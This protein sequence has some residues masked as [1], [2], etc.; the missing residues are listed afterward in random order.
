M[1]R[2]ALLLAAAT[3]ASLLS[4]GE[5]E[6]E[7]PKKPEAT[8]VVESKPTPVDIH[9]P[10]PTEGLDGIQLR[11]ANLVNTEDSAKY[12]S[13]V[14][15]RKRFVGD[16]NGVISGRNSNSI[17][18]AAALVY[19]DGLLLS[20]FLGNNY[21]FGPRWGTVAP[22]EIER[23]DLIY[24]PYSALYPGNSMGVTAWITTRE[25]QKLEA[26]LRLQ[27]FTQAYSDEYGF[28]RTFNG[29]QT[30][31]W[32]GDR[33]GR[34][35]YSVGVNHLDNLGQP[36][37]YATLLASATTTGTGPT[38]TGAGHDLDPTN[39]RRLVL[40]PTN[41]EHTVQDQAKLRFGAFITP[42]FHVAFTVAR[43]QNHFTRSSESWL[44]D[45]TG[46]PLW[47]GRTVIDGLT[48]NLSPSSPIFPF[49]DGTEATTLMGLTAK[50]KLGQSWL[51]EAILSGYQVDKDQLGSN[52][53]AA[54]AGA[55]GGAGQVAFQDGT[56]WRTGDLKAT[57]EAIGGQ[58]HLALGLH[59][60]HYRLNNRVFNATDWRQGTLTTLGSR[61]AGQ[62][63]TQAAYV[64]DAWLFSPTWTLT[65]G[66]RLER[67]KAY[68]GLIQSGTALGTLAGR[69]ESA[70]SPK[71]STTWMVQ[72]SWSLRLSV[73]K[74][75]RF[76]TVSELFQGSL[77]AGSIVNN[78]PSLKP[79]RIS[80]T[81]LTSEWTLRSGLVRLSLYEDDIRDRILRQ[82]NILVVPNITN[83][84]NVG[85]S[86][87]RGA[88]L[89]AHWV[90]L[91]PGLDLQASLSATQALTLENPR[92]PAY[93]GKWM[94]TVPRDRA[95]LVATW[96]P[97]ADWTFVL[98]AR[99]TGDTYSNPD[100]TDMNHNT[101]GG[102]SSFTMVDLKANW[103]LS[104][105][106]T[107]GLSVDNAGS[108]RAF[109]YHPYPHRTYTGELR[110]A[111]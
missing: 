89:S 77:S 17:Q 35:S 22:E 96:R 26:S 41:L 103:K 69:S 107:A 7:G 94:T 91:L 5:A 33:I 85:R 48:Y 8:V 73:G 30:S 79:E 110:W 92:Y 13:N 50:G 21:N 83:L 62:S 64:Q 86:R 34:F 99:H 104:Q 45:A 101:F 59:W 54:P 80:A 10:A 56:Y 66:L 23:V 39:A 55:A 111:F 15:V 76:P 20:N 19:S 100:G 25:P 70:A 102:A 109:I 72:D 74:A 14:L 108:A 90:E 52:T 11:E 93:E 57:G 1:G 65:A 28:S 24:G 75:T 4:A 105:R 60:D 38:A 2:I 58:H 97:R 16:R 37:Q 27:G 47:S 32:M 53:T 71:L 67:W 61:F 68:D 46:A 82:T 9:N 106:L 3:T 42:D 49:A 31:A 84:Q 95:S 98:A 44:K 12:M 43:W 87:V 18:S 29:F 63:E 6:T 36:M 88:E 51:L 81:D 78:D 40:G